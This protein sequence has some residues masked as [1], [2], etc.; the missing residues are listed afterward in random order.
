MNSWNSLTYIQDTIRITVMFE[1]GI[2]S[3]G[4]LICCIGTLIGYQTRLSNKFNNVNAKYITKNSITIVLKNIF[5]PET[6]L[7]ILLLFSKW[8]ITHRL[9]NKCYIF[10]IWFR[11]AFIR[12]ISKWMSLMW[13]QLQ[14]IVTVVKI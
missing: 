14:A 2:M 11:N 3:L 6:A 7:A 4:K 5:R 10:T 9:L 8:K 12:N 1:F 13:M